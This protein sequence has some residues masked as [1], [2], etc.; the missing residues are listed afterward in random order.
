MLGTSF[1]IIYHE[2]T[3]GTQG[4]LKAVLVMIDGLVEKGHPGTYY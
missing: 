2:F 3:M 1:D 4:I